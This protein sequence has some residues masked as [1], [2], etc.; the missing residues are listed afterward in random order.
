M[1]RFREWRRAMHWQTSVLQQGWKR[2]SFTE[3][4]SRTVMLPNGWK[5][6]RMRWKSVRMLNW[7][8]VQ[9]RLLKLLKKRSR[10]T[11]I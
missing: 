1:M 4:F 7:K 6:W 10:M 3:W 9:I 5:V 11:V 8:N 2:V